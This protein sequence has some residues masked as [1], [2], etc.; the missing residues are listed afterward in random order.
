MDS[1]TQVA[2][3]AAVSASV[4][5][6]G[7]RKKAI[8]T[9]AVLGT[10]PDLDVLVRHAKDI[11]N[12]IQ[13]RSFSHS[14]LVLP[15]VSIVLLPLVRRFYYEISWRRLYLM[16]VLAL[17]T[18]PLLDA[19]TAYSTQLFYPFDVTPTFISSV[20]I[21]DPLYTIWLLIGVTA[22]WLAARWR[23]L[24]VTG[25]AIS[26]LY[27]AL[28]IGMQTVAKSHLA[29]V[30][31]NT[32]H[33]QWFVGALTASPFC[34]RGVYKGENYYIETA[35]N[36][37][38]VEDMAVKK[39]LVLPSSYYPKSSTLKKL[40]WTNPNTVLR[41]RGKRLITSDLR[42]GEFGLYSFEFVVAPQ[43]SGNHLDMFD[44]PRWQADKK[45]LFAT[46]YD[47]RNNLDNRIKSKWLQFT[48]CLNGSV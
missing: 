5:P 21:I 41:Q 19:L 39:Y 29:T 47:Q 30:F 46:L 18:H 40:L 44:K 3:G 10:L 34:W 31:P 1:I 37:L 48:R 16:I 22:Y 8:I 12:F 27:L 9:G 13:H 42:M 38:N 25:L 20:F 17:V 7:F 32:K 14:L 26:S 36:V 24:N 11:D 23:W 15:V 2:L 28:G 6:K 43:D 35:F 45:N 33:E 4:A